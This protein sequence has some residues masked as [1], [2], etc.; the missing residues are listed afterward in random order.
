MRKVDVTLTQVKVSRS[1]SDDTFKSA[2]L[3]ARILLRPPPVTDARAWPTLLAALFF[4]ICAL[5]FAAAAILVPPV[6]MAPI[7]AHAPA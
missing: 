5:G 7:P 3:E 2:L 4:A 1:M 6:E